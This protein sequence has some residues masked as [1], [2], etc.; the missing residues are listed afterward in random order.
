MDIK[1]I[2]LPLNFASA[3]IPQ[4][5]KFSIEQIFLIR[6]LHSVAQYFMN[7]TFSN[8]PLAPFR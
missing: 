7:L 1:S 3:L 4:G 8:L 6:N 2:L 5:Q